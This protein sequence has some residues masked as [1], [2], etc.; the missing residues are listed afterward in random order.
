MEIELN[1]EESEVLENYLFK[2]AINLE[3]SGLT[4]SKCY[5]IFCSIRKKI[6]DAKKL[7]E[8]KS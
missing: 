1:E 2:K 3:N 4:D 5:K 6:L 8:R 7:N